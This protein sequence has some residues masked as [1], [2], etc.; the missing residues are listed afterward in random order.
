MPDRTIVVRGAALARLGVCPRRRL[1]VLVDCAAPL[2]LLSGEFGKFSHIESSGAELYDVG[3]KLN[4][5]R[6]GCGLPNV[7]QQCWAGPTRETS[8]EDLTRDGHE[9]KE[10]EQRGALLFVPY[11]AAR[12]AR[13]STEAF[14]SSRSR[15]RRDTLR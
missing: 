8:G 5:L 10:S 6:S 9:R 1:V 2:C 14:G 12:A 15:V 11:G 3:K 4:H 7:P 13:L